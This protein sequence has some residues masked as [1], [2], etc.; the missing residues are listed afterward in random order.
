MEIG[1]GSGA[2]H[3]VGILVCLGA[4]AYFG[5]YLPERFLAWSL[6][7][8]F[9][10]VAAVVAA[11]GIT[12]DFRGLLIDD[13]NKMS[14]SR[15]QVVAWLLITL[16]ALLTATL[17]NMRVSDKLSRNSIPE[18]PNELL[19]LFAITGASAVSAPMIRGAKRAARPDP[20]EANRTAKQLTADDQGLQLDVPDGVILRNTNPASARWGD[21]LKG[22]EAGN[23]AVID[24]GKLQMFFT[25]FV[26]LLSY[27]AMLGKTFAGNG[28][29]AALPAFS[30]GFN[31]LLGISHTG[32]LTYKASPHTREAPPSQPNGARGDNG[33]REGFEELPDA[34]RLGTP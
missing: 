18:L 8:A 22:D 29:V 1:K 33:Q 20:Y 16:A 30:E 21:L 14:L 4:V 24:L 3:V 13:R 26:L 10:A 12:G 15:L 9:F 11:H 25:T 23:A 7:A 27:S 32:Y 5:L 6:V 28:F 19:I 17:G 31:L 34:A 2:V